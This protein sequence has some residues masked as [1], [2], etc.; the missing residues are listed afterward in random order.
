MNIKEELAQQALGKYILEY[1]TEDK[2]DFQQMVD[3]KATKILGEI[4]DKFQNNRDDWDDFLLIDEII[5][6]LNENGISTGNC[7]DY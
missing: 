4:Q 6:I 2:P 7:H 1:L 5:S 3:T